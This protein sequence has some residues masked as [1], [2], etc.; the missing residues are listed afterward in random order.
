MA[1]YTSEARNNF[2][3]P[4]QQKLLPLPSPQRSSFP[5]PHPW[6][7]HVC[8]YGVAAA[9]AARS[10]LL[11][12]QTTS[13]LNQTGWFVSTAQLATSN[14]SI[15]TTTIPLFKNHLP[16]LSHPLP[17]NIIT[18]TFSPITTNTVT[19]HHYYTHHHWHVS[20]QKPPELPPPTSS[21]PPPQR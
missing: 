6:A 12:N 21:S 8:S 15:V 13:A 3:S 11:P 2:L 18:I 20:Q 4:N 5:S 9:A 16:T 19:H 17:M 14:T 1:S 7:L 10:Y